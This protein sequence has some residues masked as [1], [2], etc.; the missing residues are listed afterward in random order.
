VAEHVHEAED[1]GVRLEVRGQAAG[2]NVSGDAGRL[3]TAFDAIF[4]AILREKP[5][6]CTVVVDRRIVLEGARS[7]AVVVVADEGSVQTAYDAPSGPFDEKRGGLGLALPIARRV[8]EWH[9]GRLWSTADAGES[10]GNKGTAL[11]ALPIRG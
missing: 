6:P 7:S 5:G 1:R 8:I 2:G 9:G 4:R 11:I 3:R 10:G